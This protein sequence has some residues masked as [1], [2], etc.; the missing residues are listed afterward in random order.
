MRCAVLGL[1]GATGDLPGRLRAPRRA[2]G[3]ATPAV[4]PDSRLAREA[5]ERAADELSP[6]VLAHA[7]RCW[8]WSVAFADVDRLAPDREL[9]FV[10]AV[11]HDLELGAPDHPDHGC[12]ASLS[13]ARAGGL[14]A[15]HRGAEDAET[16]RRAIAG[17]FAPWTPEDPVARVLHSAVNLDVVGRR[18]HDLDP[19][20]VDVVED[21]HP[22]TGFVPVFTAALRVEAERRPRSAA[23]VL[24]RTGAVLPIRANPLERRSRG[25]AA[26]G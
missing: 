24:W 3:G 8:Q 12:F 14:V 26:P 13:G 19:G 15:A 16:V 1:T 25:R 20:L 18:L 7:Y 23:A 21:R 17:H 6:E 2:A 11:L 9:T 10:A 22:R 5:A 4:P